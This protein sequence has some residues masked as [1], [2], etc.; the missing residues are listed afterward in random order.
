MRTLFQFRQLCISII[1]LSHSKRFHAKVPYLST[2]HDFIF[3][4]EKMC[5]TVGIKSVQI[6]SGSV[7]IDTSSENFQSWY[8]K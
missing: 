8:Q 7:V 1:C 2:E 3:D 5:H 6:G 4:S